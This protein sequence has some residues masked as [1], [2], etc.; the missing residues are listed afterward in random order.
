MF[1]W[2]PTL[3]SPT[4]SNNWSFYVFFFNIWVSLG[5]IIIWTIQVFQHVWCPLV[6]PE[7]KSSIRH[8][9]SEDPT[10]TMQKTPKWSHPSTT[11]LPHSDGPWAPS[12]FAGSG[13]STPPADAPGA[14][15][16]LAPG[17]A[18]SQT[19]RASSRR[20]CARSATAKR[21]GQGVPLPGKVPGM[22]F[23][24]I[25]YRDLRCQFFFCVIYL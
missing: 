9:T 1:Q 11:G 4:I 5:C 25:S 19:C 24:G 23:L 2:L 15:I 14:T 6:P 10:N 20:R 7:K 16:H 13:S 22:L 3:K 17:A 8:E 18:G 12:S 21:C